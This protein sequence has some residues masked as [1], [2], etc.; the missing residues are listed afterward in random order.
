MAALIAYPMVNS[1]IAAVVYAAALVPLVNGGN[2]EALYPL[3]FRL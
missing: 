2:S 3:N 1:G